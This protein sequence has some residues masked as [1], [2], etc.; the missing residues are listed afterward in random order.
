MKQITNI[1]QLKT[2]LKSRVLLSI[3]YQECKVIQQALKLFD[4]MPVED[5]PSTDKLKIAIKEIEKALQSQERVESS[6]LNN[7]E[8]CVGDVCEV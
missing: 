3:D 7:S 6:V 1:T 5:K 2:H 8:N 4:A